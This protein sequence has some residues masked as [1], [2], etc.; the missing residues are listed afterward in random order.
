MARKRYPHSVDPKQKHLT[1][2]SEE[3][4]HV[5]I[6]A[7]LARGGKTLTGSELK[8]FCVLSS[9][10]PCYPS[11]QTIMRDAGLGKSATLSALNGLLAKR[12]FIKSSGQ[13]T[14][15]N[16]DY[17]RLPEGEWVFLDPRSKTDLGDGL[18]QTNAR[19]ET[20]LPLGLKSDHQIDQI[21]RSINS[22][23]ALRHLS[24]A[25]PSFPGRE[26]RSPSGPIRGEDAEKG[27]GL[28]ADE[29]RARDALFKKIDEIDARAFDRKAVVGEDLQLSGP[30]W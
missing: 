4:G 27:V 26:Q 19:S 30:T 3:I 13:R 15:S 12:F 11:L 24:E 6:P 28:T 5:R 17:F 20:D 16:N 23:N 21:N 8:V 14:R 1:L 10:N 25:E 7:F 18:K 9:Y 22:D 29:I 2:N